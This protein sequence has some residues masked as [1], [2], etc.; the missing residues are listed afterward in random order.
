MKELFDRI[1]GANFLHITRALRVMS[2]TVALKIK[3]AKTPEAIRKIFG[4]KAEFTPEEEARIRK[5]H[6]WCEDAEPEGEEAA[7]TAAAPD[8]EEAAP[9][10]AAP[11]DDVDI[12]EK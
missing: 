7:P 2:I 11:A 3:E 6:P 1:N 9:T 5:E 4:I 8:G 12:A 10:A